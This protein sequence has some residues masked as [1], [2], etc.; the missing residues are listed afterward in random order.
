MSRAADVIERA[1]GL[2]AVVSAEAGP[3]ELLRTMSAPVVDAMW[4]TGLMTYMNPAAA[5]GAEPSFGDMIDT[6]QRMAYLD[7]SFGWIGIA[8]LPSAAAVAV[9]SPTRASRRRS[10]R[11]SGSRWAGSSRPTARACAST[12]A[13]SSPACGTSV[14]ASGTRSSCAAGFLP[15]VDGKPEVDGA[16]DIVL[17]TAV[18]PRDEI[19]FTDGWFVQGL[20]GTGSY[21]YDVVDLF[22]PD[23]R[24][25]RSS[26]VNRTAATRRRTAWA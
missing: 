11:P 18:I 8:N 15:I 5:G 19:N 6:W 25:S 1:R 24:S 14:R 9:T 26:R 17:L 10:A 21:D 2:R 13:T 12:A 22:V 23:Q 16:G 4:R 7:G 3:S 20:Q